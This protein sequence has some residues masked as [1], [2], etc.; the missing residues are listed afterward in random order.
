MLTL[1]ENPMGT[2]GFEFIEFTA[3]DTGVLARLFERMGFVAVARHRHK[4]VTVY[5]QGDINFIINH[6]PH[7]FAQAFARVHGPSVCAFAIRVRDAAAAFER[8]VKLGA[9]P[10]HVPVGPMELN[11]PAILGIGRSL[12]YFV[13][14]YGEQSIYDVDFMPIPGV[15]RNPQGVGLTHI[16][17]LTHNVPEG[18]MD[19]WAHFYERLFNFQEIRYFDIHGKATGLKSRAMTSPCGKIRIPI[20]EPSDK[21]SQIQEYLE[22]YHGEGI[23]HIALATEDI[24]QTVETLHHQ[25]VEFMGVPDTYYDAVEAR[26]P[27]HGEDLARLHQDRILID[28]APQQGQGL[29]LQLFTQTMIGPIFFEIIQRKGNQGFG[30]GN[31]QALFEAIEQDQIKRGAI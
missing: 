17:H 1:P 24:Y 15:S 16:D 12:I 7:S 25:G 19:H 26:I 31:F 3:P 11:I 8:A 14:R 30:E 20:N 4:D 2:D 23:Q 9:E 5:R 6:E 27:Q 21:K 22:A 13:D 29:L 18:R 10:F 28:G